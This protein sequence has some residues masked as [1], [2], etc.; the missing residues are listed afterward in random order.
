[1]SIL[2]LKPFFSSIYSAH[3]L[4][5]PMLSVILYTLFEYNRQVAI[6]LNTTSGLNRTPR[7]W[8]WDAYL[9]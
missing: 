1:M 3:P 2:P 7:N 6:A 8:H 5:L 4:L 9:L